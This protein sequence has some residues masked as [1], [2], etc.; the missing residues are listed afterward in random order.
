MT[1]NATPRKKGWS[2]GATVAD[3]RKGARIYRNRHDPA[4]LRSLH[5]T[6]ELKH[7]PHWW[8]Q[9]LKPRYIRH[10]R[11]ALSFNAYTPITDTDSSYY[12][13]NDTF[14]GLKRQSVPDVEHY[15]GRNGAPE[16][17]RIV[18]LSPEE[19]E[20]CRRKFGRDR[21]K[22]VGLE[23]YCNIPQTNG[24][25]AVVTHDFYTPIGGRVYTG[26]EDV[27]QALHA[28]LDSH[29]KDRRIRGTR[30][31][32]VATRE[33]SEWSLYAFTTLERDEYADI[34]RV[35]VSEGLISH[36]KEREHTQGTQVQHEFS[37]DVCGKDENVQEAN[38]LQVRQR[39]EL[40]LKTKR[41]S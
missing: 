6:S 30:G 13:L 24:N 26:S 40:H 5:F 11:T 25:H 41:T 10:I 21:K 20:R 9:R 28:V 23:F 38:L 3:A 17:I 8:K 14:P 4:R 1:A 19:W 12:V 32:P 7:D 31:K 36:L 39:L 37:F 33:E 22:L 15:E 29:D 16:S 2:E 35:L 27:L 34:L 18:H